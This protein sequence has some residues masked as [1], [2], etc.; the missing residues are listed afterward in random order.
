M[1]GVQAWKDSEKQKVQKRNKWQT[2]DEGVEDDDADCEFDEEGEELPEEEANWRKKE[3]AR[4]R[5]EARDAMEED[6]GGQEIDVGEQGPKQVWQEDGK[7]DDVSI[8]V[9]AAGRLVLMMLQEFTVDMML[10]SLNI[11]L[12]VIGWDAHAQRWNN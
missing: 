9:H 10:R 6:S 1:G 7:E 5:Q 3:K 11:D 4:M 2:R 8:E 12:S